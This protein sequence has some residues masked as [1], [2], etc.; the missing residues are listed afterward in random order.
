MSEKRGRLPE[1]EGDCPKKREIARKEG[2]CPKKR[3]ICRQLRDLLLIR[4]LHCSFLVQFLVFFVVISGLKIK[5]M[6]ERPPFSPL[7][8]II[9]VNEKCQD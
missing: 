4:H 1:K 2:D 9:F 7:N 5:N 8:S 6:F 3:E